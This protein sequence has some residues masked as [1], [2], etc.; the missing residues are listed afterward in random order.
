MLSLKD[1]RSPA[2]GLDWHEAVAVGAALG[3]L[4]AESRAAA[5]PRPVDV[6]LLPSGDLRVTG[7][8]TSTDR[9]LPES[10]TC[11]VSC[12]RRRPTRRSCGC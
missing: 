5:C 12:S 8:G 9:P 1:L 2:A 6:T 3:D 10:R 4:L 11:S 7:A